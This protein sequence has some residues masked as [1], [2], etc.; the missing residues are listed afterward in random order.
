MEFYRFVWRQDCKRNLTDGNLIR[1]CVQREF[2]VAFSWLEEFRL[3][4]VSGWWTLDK[5]QYEN[6]LK[7]QL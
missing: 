4:K 1:K 7:D 5:L 6:G 3:G 2:D